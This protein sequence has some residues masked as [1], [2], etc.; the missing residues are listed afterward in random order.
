MFTLPRCVA[1]ATAELT[2]RPT[3]HS[4]VVARSVKLDAA[5]L[6]FSIHCGCA[7]AGFR[8][9]VDGARL[10]VVGLGRWLWQ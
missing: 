9:R 10:C 8:P 2:H 3:G 5:L 7:N 4:V 6:F 1:L